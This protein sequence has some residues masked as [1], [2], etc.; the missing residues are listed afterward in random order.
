V[1]VPPAL[2]N[3][4]RTRGLERRGE[5]PAPQETGYT[6]IRRRIERSGVRAECQREREDALADEKVGDAASSFHG[7]GVSN[8]SLAVTIFGHG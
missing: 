6:K 2:E 3:A 1:G 8:A 7:F 5:T 4:G